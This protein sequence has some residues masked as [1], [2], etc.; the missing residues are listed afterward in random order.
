MSSPYDF[1]NDLSKLKL[2]LDYDGYNEGTENP[3][4]EEPVSFSPRPSEN[5]VLP[6]LDLSFLNKKVD[7]NPLATLSTPGEKSKGPFGSIGGKGSGVMDNIGS[8]ANYGVQ[9]ANMF[10]NVAGSEKESWAGLGSSVA[11]GAGVGMSVGGP[12]GAAI[13][14]GVGLVTG[15]VDFIGDTNKR[16]EK[17]RDDYDKSFLENMNKRKEEWGTEKAERNLQKLTTLRK[18]QLNYLDLDI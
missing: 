17:A 2:S 6:E 3:Y 14:A 7:A 10:S 12:V 8:I 5:V 16:N 4:K 1:N 11:G 9:Q 18:S 15:A 13:G